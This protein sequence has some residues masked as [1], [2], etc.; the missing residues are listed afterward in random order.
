MEVNENKLNVVRIN[1]TQNR[2]RL[3]ASHLSTEVRERIISLMIFHESASTTARIASDEFRGIR[4]TDRLVMEVMVLRRPPVRE[5][6]IATLQR[7]SA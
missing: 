6:S 5:T 7:R 3:S 4:I 2:K 1:R